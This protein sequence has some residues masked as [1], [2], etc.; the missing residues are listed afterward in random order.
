MMR[1]HLY[2]GGDTRHSG[3]ATVDLLGNAASRPFFRENDGLKIQSLSEK[4]YGSIPG[5]QIQFAR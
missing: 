4:P 2:T 1:G 3:I 5:M